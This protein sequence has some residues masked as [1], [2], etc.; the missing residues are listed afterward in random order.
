M[1]FQQLLAMYQRSKSLGRP[2][3][4]LTVKKSDLHDA[5]TMLWK[6]LQANFVIFRDSTTQRPNAN[7]KETT[8]LRLHSHRPS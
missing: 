3:N 4:L 8:L 6:G 1:N 7:R 5:K 2:P